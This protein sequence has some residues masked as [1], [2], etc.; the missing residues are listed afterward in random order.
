MRIIGVDE[1]F[2]IANRFYKG[3]LISARDELKEILKNDWEV[4]KAMRTSN[5]EKLI[6][7]LKP[8]EHN[9]MS[10][11]YLCTYCIWLIASVDVEQANKF[12]D[13]ALKYYE[14]NLFRLYGLILDEIELTN[15]RLPY[16][17]WCGEIKQLNWYL[18]KG[19]EITP[20]LLSKLL[21]QYVR[22]SDIDKL[23]I[24]V[25]DITADHMTEQEI[26]DYLSTN[27]IG[28]LDIKQVEIVEN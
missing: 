7:L 22:C 6:P 16:T 2:D 24:H 10:G 3:S 27:G 17:V 13:Y 8:I 1:N 25:S 4:E 14:G 18:A 21:I 12:L 20:A 15:K 19:V 23:V 26:I 5:W 28:M 9:M 11:E